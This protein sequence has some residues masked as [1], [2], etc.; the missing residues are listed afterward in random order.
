M[1]RIAALAL[2]L[3]FPLLPVVALAE[4]LHGRVVGVADGDTLTIL[5]AGNIQHKIRLAGIDAPEKRQP[6]GER[7]RQHLGHLAHG[8]DAAAL[9]NKI[10]RYRRR[11]CKVL[12]QSPDCPTCEKTLDVG[13]A[14][15]AVGAAWWYREYAKEQSPEDRARYESAEQE[16]RTKRV[17]CQRR[18]EFR[19]IWPVWNSWQE[20]GL[21]R[22]R[23]LRD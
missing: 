9:C 6:F 23:E 3:M 20:R 18:R 21:C 5:A 12:V 15:V 2:A 7:S 10:D 19:L 17:G 14:Q 1:L 16:A 11:V 4:T 22:V 8:K 13:L